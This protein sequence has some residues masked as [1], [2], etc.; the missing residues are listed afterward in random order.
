MS[1]SHV[2]ITADALSQAVADRVNDLDLASASSEGRPIR[3]RPG[4]WLARLAAARG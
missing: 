2:N 3:R 4:S 1:T